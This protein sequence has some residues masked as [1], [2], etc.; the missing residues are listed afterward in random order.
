MDEECV[1]SGIDK[2]YDYSNFVNSMY[3]SSNVNSTE[4]SR[5]FSQ[6][7]ILEESQLI[8]FDL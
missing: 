5:Y 1:S 2:T 7:W 4:S 6:V 8:R 3:S